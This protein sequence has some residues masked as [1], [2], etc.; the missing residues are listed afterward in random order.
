MNLFSGI[1]QPKSAAD[2]LSTVAIKVK[3]YGTVSQFFHMN[4]KPAS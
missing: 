3:K 4:S 2:R 1:K